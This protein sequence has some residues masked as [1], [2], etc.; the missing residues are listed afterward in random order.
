MARIELSV[1][2]IGDVHDAAVIEILVK[3][4]ATI[5]AEQ[6]LITI[7]SDKASME[8]PS[9]HAGVLQE[10]RVKLGDKVSQGSIIAVL[11]TA[12]DAVAAPAEPVAVPS[13]VRSS[14]NTTTMRVNDVIITTIDGA[15]LRTVSRPTS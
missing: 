6:S 3:P 12:S 4:G 15:R 7:E 2:D 8:V 11:E 5:K 9:S 14:D 13:A 1:P 10:L